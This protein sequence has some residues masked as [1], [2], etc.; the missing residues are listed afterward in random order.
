MK[1]ERGDEAHTGNSSVLRK[2]S[3]RQK[4]KKRGTDMHVCCGNSVVFCYLGV[5]LPSQLCVCVY[6]LFLLTCACERVAALG[7]KQ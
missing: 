2:T 1:K 4:K 6:V 5:F 3:E 7:E